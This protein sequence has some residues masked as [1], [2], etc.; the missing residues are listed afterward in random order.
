VID[1][2]HTDECP[3]CGEPV[4][5]LTELYRAERRFDALVCCE[6]GRWLVEAYG[7]WDAL[8]RRYWRRLFAE[9]GAE[10]RSVYADELEIG[11]DFGVELDAIDRR[12]AHAFIREHHAHNGAPAGELFAI[13]ARNGGELVAVALIGRPVARHNDDGRTWELT[14]VCT[15]R[16]L[17]PRLTSNAVS[18]IAGEIARRAR[19]QGVARLITYTLA[20]ESGA[21]LEA[22]GFA[23]VY[24]TRPERR[25]WHRPSRPRSSSTT[26]AGR[27]WLWERRL[28]RDAGPIND[29]ARA[30]ERQ[31]ALFAHH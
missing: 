8:P 25:G 3:D 7:G 29:R 23:R 21:S 2:E 11:L 30:A 24:R 22:S 20:S 28:T 16:D 5:T 15:R 6:Y 27:K 4:I 13:G 17:H 14:R 31:P 9:I 18:Q 19:R 1:L 26:P 12:T 10:V